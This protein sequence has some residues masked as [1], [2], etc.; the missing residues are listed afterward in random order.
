[1]QDRPLHLLLRVQVD[2]HR[3]H[4]ALLIIIVAATA[5]DE[6]CFDGRAS[7]WLRISRCSAAHRKRGDENAKSL[8]GF[9]DHEF[10]GCKLL[11]LRFGIILIEF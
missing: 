11:F 10:D 5:R 2:A 4:F 8:C 9:L 7:D 6:E 3:D 1:M